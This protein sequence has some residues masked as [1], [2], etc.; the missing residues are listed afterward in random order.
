MGITV[1]LRT[2]AVSETLR[3]SQPCFF[4]AATRGFP[5][6]FGLVGNFGD[7]ESSSGG[8]GWRKSRSHIPCRAQLQRGKAGGRLGEG[9]KERQPCGHKHNTWLE[10]PTGE[11][12]GIYSFL[13]PPP[14]VSPSSNALAEP[15]CG[16]PAISSSPLLSAPMGGSLSHTVPFQHLQLV[17]GSAQCSTKTEEMD[18]TPR[19][20][21]RH[22]LA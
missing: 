20:I 5:V 16:T 15:S 11:G 19:I 22:N 21:T 18:S 6:T 9:G 10:V 7:G 14:L 4:C 12:K 1:L 13:N 3:Y 8:S 17:S 2:P